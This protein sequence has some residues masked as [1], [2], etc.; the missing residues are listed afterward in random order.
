MS[1]V[2]VIGGRR[3]GKSAVAERL[4]G[5]TGTYLAT[6]AATDEEMV[7]RIAIHRARRG[8]GWDTVQLG[9]DL[10]VALDGATSPILLDG[11][12]AWIAGVMHRHRAFASRE[13]DA[14]VEAVVREGI[15]AL[16]RPREG[17]IVVVAEE[18]GLGPV[19]VEPATRKWLDLM[20]DATQAVAAAADRVLLV[21]AGR[22]LELPA[23]QTPAPGRVLHGDKLVRPGDD[24]FA[25][26]V[27]EGPPP[28]WLTAAI[29]GAELCA[30]PDEADATAAIATRHDLE[31]A[32]VLVLNGAA[33]AF[34]LVAAAT[35]RGPRAAVVM[36]SFGEPPA[37][38]RAYG[39]APVSVARSA[40]DG[41]ALHTDDVPADAGLVVVANPCNPTGALHAVD[42]VLA[43]ARPGRTLV[44]D[45]SFMDFVAEPQP[46]VAGRTDVPGLVVLRSLTKA[47][48]VAGLRAGYLLGAPDLVARLAARRQA[49][50]VNAPALGA[51]AA[52]ARRPPDGELVRTIAE[53]RA[54]L[55]QR[56]R[57]L[58]GVHVY[59]GAA[60]FL[61][62]RVPDGAQAVERLRARRIA[63][64]PTEDLGLDANHIRV[65]VRDEAATDRLVSALGEV[66]R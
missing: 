53:Q 41:F 19:P 39:H 15:A 12:G 31:P 8:A 25:V 32:S 65:A 7:A 43:L 11:L 23:D 24:D 63:V 36:P 48:S 10:A 42:D 27:V 22:T 20:G 51:L 52:W 5:P 30:Y 49:W 64:R 45:E 34:W 28:A 56:L 6:G 47:H 44:V 29:D 37:A 14:A 35:A 38:L 13:R 17:L 58:P 40:E 50:P 60:N 3:S 21:V 55:A 26:N 16:T 33:E 18:A 9:D 1:L 66:L 4:V 62:I 57:A 59:D 54:R 2:V 46:S 61:L